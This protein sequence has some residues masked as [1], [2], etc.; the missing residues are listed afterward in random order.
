M[1]T[2]RLS[3]FVIKLGLLAILLI[4]GITTAIIAVDRTRA[5]KNFHEYVDQQ[6]NALT[7]HL[8]NADAT[9]SGIAALYQAREAFNT[10]ELTTFIHE[11]LSQSPYI[12]HIL[13][14]PRVS[15]AEK[16]ALVTK[17]RDAGFPMFN[18]SELTAHRMSPAR[19][20]ETYY[21]V[22]FIEPMKP[23]SVHLLGFD[24]LSVPALKRPMAEAGQGGEI[25]ISPPVGLIGAP[26]TWA[27]KA[28]Y[29]GH[30]SPET[31]AE[32]QRRL[33]GFVAIQLDLKRLAM[34]Q[35]A[36]HPALD[37]S[38]TVK[39]R[40]GASSNLVP[41]LRPPTD[42]GIRLF[43]PL[44]YS[45]E[46]SYHNATL[47]FRFN[48]AVQTNEIRTPLIL[49]LD[50]MAAL[51]VLA[52]GFNRFRRRMEEIDEQE[53]RQQIRALQERARITLQSIGDA[54]ITTNVNGIVEY[55]NPV[56]EQ[57]TG[58]DLEEAK[59]H[60]LK[61]LFTLVD[62]ADETPLPCP[63]EKCLKNHKCHQEDK[64][65]L[66][67]RNDGETIPVDESVAPITNDDEDIS[68]VVLVLRDASVERHLTAHLTYQALH[69][70]LTALSNRRDFEDKLEHALQQAR[71]ES[72]QHAVLYLDLDQFKLVN[73]S[74]GH[75]AGDTLLKQV[76]AALRTQL[77]PS[78][79]LARLGGDEFGILLSHCPL[80]DAER[81]AAKICKS[82]ED[83]HFRW[84][85]KLFKISVSIGIVV[86]DSTS[87]S[88]T[89]VL[90]AADSACFIAKDL[91]RNRFHVYQP[92]DKE[93]SRREMELQSVHHIQYALKH[94]ALSL[95]LQPI[96]AAQHDKGGAFMGEF[97]VRMRDKEGNPVLPF[98]F[99]PTAERYGMMK[100]IDQWVVCHAMQRIAAD[101]A[102]Q[103]EAGRD[104]CDI[105][106]INLSGQSLDDPAM[107]EFIARSAKK[108]DV[109]PTS[110]CFEITET[111]AITHLERALDMINGLRDRGFLFALDDF[112]T[113][114]SSFAYLKK[115]P[116]DF[117]K[118]D[119]EFVRDMEHDKVDQAMVETINNIAHV[120][121]I[122]T[123]AEFVENEALQHMLEDMGVDYLQG[124]HLGRPAPVPLP[125]D[126]SHQLEATG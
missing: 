2:F 67:L 71:T 64:Y 32:R 118:I 12:D 95:C 48:T 16:Q 84:E 117:L 35:F 52:L 47:D 104:P 63:V 77:R 120:L 70:S 91:G 92:D 13:Y 112:G 40:N 78:D 94:G 33:R 114:L 111:A 18:I 76:A 5:E 65:V 107:V 98:A 121:N 72:V 45:R 39:P 74:A 10:P 23:T 1:K 62:E 123:I 42:E 22:T 81:I 15:A 29:H 88:L 34:D 9:L 3:T 26:S 27:F 103:I 102:G 4:A 89:A 125:L 49:S 90:S 113:G 59:G 44:S 41:A 122:K 108:W 119:G 110:V 43:P 11:V 68:G 73:D 20:R 17:M 55:I 79:L 31:A 115:I 109:D 25:A 85:E 100:S 105:Y 126:R 69:D 86:I 37:L 53:K 36:G 82:V 54:V 101:R 19:L 124:Y 6:I 28:V 30:D 80:E 97:L 83:I 75:V 116:V 46:L 57:L 96:V 8:G 24:A 56:A 7:L 60:K 14:L 50:G 99:I 106:T 93:V 87:S 38:L 66:L 21:P 61:D 51:L 58:W